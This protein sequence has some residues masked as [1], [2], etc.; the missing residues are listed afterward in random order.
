MLS[1]AYLVFCIWAKS[2]VH[3]GLEKAL[4][5]LAVERWS[6][7]P[8]PLN[9]ILWT[10]IGESPEAYHQVY[11][12]IL[13]DPTP[14]RV[15]HFPKN[16]ALRERW[17]KDHNVSRLMEMTKGMFLLE[18]KEDGTL[19]FNDLRFG[20]MGGWFDGNTPF[21]FHYI[22]EGE[23]GNSRVHPGQP[24]R[25]RVNDEAWSSLWERMMGGRT[26]IGS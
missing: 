7:R 17:A 13:D 25:D 5:P 8:A 14:L 16:Q 22:V 6:S 18:K 26:L 3:P 24:S 4:Q 11:H 23:P 1:S 2:A 21:V 15:H 10:A 19:L 9:A 20:Q 12:S